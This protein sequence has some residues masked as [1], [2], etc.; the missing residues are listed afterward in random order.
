MVQIPGILDFPRTP[1][2][3]RSAF[4][5]RPAGVRSVEPEEVT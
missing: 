3:A 5:A 2:V 4:S 1:D